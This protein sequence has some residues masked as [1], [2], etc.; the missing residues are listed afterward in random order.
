MPPPFAEAGTQEI[1]AETNLDIDATVTITPTAATSQ[2]TRYDYYEDGVLLMTLEPG[3]H[4]SVSESIETDLA[5][6]ATLSSS[7][8]F[9]VQRGGLARV[10]SGSLSSTV[11]EVGGKIIAEGSYSVARNGE[12]FTRSLYFD[13]PVQGGGGGKTFG[14]FFG[15]V[16]DCATAGAAIGAAAGGVGGA[17]IGG[18][19]GGSAGAAAGGV[20]AL[21]GA[22]AGA[23][24]G[25]VI[26]AGFGAVAGGGGGAIVCGTAYLC[27]L[28]DKWF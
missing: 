3:Q 25:A 18:V 24:S 6:V 27:G 1:T 15:A 16:G 19:A 4:G 28:W 21:P 7:W 11:S 26:G 8:S 22:V 5:G 14:G 17:V 13:P 2:I 10:W 12:S 20:G 9:P 23:K